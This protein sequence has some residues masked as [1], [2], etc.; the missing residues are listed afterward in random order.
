MSSSDDEVMS[1]DLAVIDFLYAKHDRYEW[2]DL[3]ISLE[4][5]A[6]FRNIV[7]N[8]AKIFDLWKREFDLINNLHMTNDLHFHYVFNDQCRPFIIKIENLAA[9]IT[10]GNHLKRQNY[11]EPFAIGQTSSLWRIHSEMICKLNEQIEKTSRPLDFSLIRINPGRLPSGK[12]TYFRNLVIVYE[13]IEIVKY[14]EKERHCLVA[15]VLSGQILL[16]KKNQCY[17]E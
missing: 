12:I 3:E 6:V 17:K 10:K 14:R 9:T 11:L 7:L 5:K 8:D 1:E 2:K 15:R 13:T 16:L 4:E